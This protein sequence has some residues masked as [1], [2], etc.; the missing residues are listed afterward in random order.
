MTQV[1]GW[2]NKNIL[3]I[4]SQSTTILKILGLKNLQIST[5]N[6]SQ[7][8]IQPLEEVRAEKNVL[9]LQV[10]KK[11]NSDN[12]VYEAVQY[13]VREQQHSPLTSSESSLSVLL[14]SWLTT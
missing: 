3:C 14:L 9:T 4:V 6:Y 7:T 1:N 11:K 2:I 10:K 12:R 8:L 13:K 5:A